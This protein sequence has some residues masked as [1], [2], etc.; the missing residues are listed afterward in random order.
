MKIRS[1]YWAFLLWLVAVACSSPPVNAAANPQHSV[2]ESSTWPVRLHVRSDFDGD[3]VPDTAVVRRHGERYT[4]I[5]HFAGKSSKTYS[6]YY[7]RE[8]VVGIASMDVDGDRDRD[9]VLLGLNSAL[10]A[11]L[12]LNESPETF[13]TEVPWLVAIIYPDSLARISRSFLQSP[14]PDPGSLTEPGPD[15]SVTEGLFLL[16]LRSEI[17]LCSCSCPVLLQGLSVSV[18]SR[19]PPLNS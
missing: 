11:G 17:R 16:P 9:I 6:A 10:P 18:P 12:W 2:V 14:D 5:I 15:A 8:P 4:L 3:Q 19:G 13:R 7:T 1:P